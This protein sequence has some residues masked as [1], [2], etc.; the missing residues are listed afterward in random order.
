MAFQVR[1]LVLSTLS[2]GLALAALLSACGGGD[3]ATGWATDSAGSVTLQFEAVAGTTPVSCGSTIT[4]LGSTSK[5]AQIQDLRFYVS[6]VQL[7]KA[8]GSTVPLTLATTDDNNYA[9]ANGSVSL[10]TLSQAGTGA[11]TTGTLNTAIQGTVPAGRYVGVTMTL[12]VPMGLNHLSSTDAATPA[13]L[14]SDVNPSMSWNWR[15]GR[16]FTKIELQSTEA[17]NPVTLLH[18]GSTGCVGDPAN[19]VPITGCTAPNRLTLSFA[20]FD[21]ARQQIALDVQSLFAQQNFSVTN[22]CMSSPT[23]AGC[24]S[25]F[26]AL[27]LN[28]NPDGTGTG[29]AVAGQTQTVFKAMSR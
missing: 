18:L 15:G 14:R 12:G 28:F 22:S 4:G 3:D 9:D 11:C 6:D 2:A 8:D 20:D 29:T 25:D 21:P 10:I 24:V 1:P 26:A 5:S 23:D 27:A 19:G 17:G 16:K 13:V 7:I